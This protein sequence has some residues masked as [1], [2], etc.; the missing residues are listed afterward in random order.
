MDLSSSQFNPQESE[1]FPEVLVVSLYPLNFR[2]CL[3]LGQKDGTNNVSLY[4]LSATS[5]YS[6]GNSTCLN[7]KNPNECTETCLASFSEAISNNVES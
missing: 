4:C 3:N 6:E 5:S 2:K 1:N 7:K